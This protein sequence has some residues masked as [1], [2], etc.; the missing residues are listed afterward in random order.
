MEKILTVLLSNEVILGYIG[1]I[2]FAIYTWLKNRAKIKDERLQKGLLFLEEG[3]EEVWKEVVKPLKMAAAKGKLSEVD[4]R[5]CLDIAKNKAY[6]YAKREG[7]NLFT[8][9]AEETIPVLI[10]RIVDSR[11]PSNLTATGKND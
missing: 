7:W 10:R 8:Y 6:S 1:S 5:N 11:K 2:I 3:V 4:K 9:I